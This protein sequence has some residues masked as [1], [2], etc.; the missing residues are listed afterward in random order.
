MNEQLDWDLARDAIEK[1]MLSE[2]ERIEWFQRKH[3]QAETYKEMAEDS[4]VCRER[5][6]KQLIEFQSEMREELHPLREIL[7]A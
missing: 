6:R 4:N 2:D 1:A 3:L 7:A 5:L